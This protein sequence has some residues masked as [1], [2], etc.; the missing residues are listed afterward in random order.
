MNSKR[1]ADWR[2]KSKSATPTDASGRISRGNAT[3]FTRFAL[4]I[5]DRDPAC[6]AFEKKLHASSPDSK[7]TGKS[8][9]G[10]PR[11]VTKNENTA[12]KT[13]GFSRDH[14]APRTDAVYFTFSSLR[15]MLTK[16]LAMREKLSDPRPDV[17]ARRLGGSLD[18]D[19]GDDRTPFD[20]PLDR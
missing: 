4:S 12:R 5:T 20:A 11:T 6:S 13:T 15:T 18:G 3:F 14:T 17:E 16:H 2:T 9:I 1:T 7:K 8:G 19:R 10:L